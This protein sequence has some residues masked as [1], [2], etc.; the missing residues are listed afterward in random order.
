MPTKLALSRK[1]IHAIVPRTLL[2]YAGVGLGMGVVPLAT[3]GC[4][5]GDTTIGIIPAMDIDADIRDGATS[6][7]LPETSVG[8]RPAMDVD[9]GDATDL[10]DSAVGIRP[11]M[12]VDADIDASAGDD[13]GAEQDASDGG[14]TSSSADSG[15][16][17]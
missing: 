2:A 7:A 5:S 12:N 14:T 10:P 17:P 8:I 1:R 6:D 13:A 15:V 11:A 16:G 3:V 9:G 4:D